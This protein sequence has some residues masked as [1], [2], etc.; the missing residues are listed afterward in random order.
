MIMELQSY[1]W[2]LSQSCIRKKGEGPI[3]ISVCFMAV[4][5]V[6]TVNSTVKTRDMYM[7]V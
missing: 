2:Q 6:W 7:Y 1:Q 5:T 3:I 4:F